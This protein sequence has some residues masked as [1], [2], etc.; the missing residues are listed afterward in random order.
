[1][2]IKYKEILRL[3]GIMSMIKLKEFGIG[4]ETWMI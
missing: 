3:E 4:D 1:M 2:R